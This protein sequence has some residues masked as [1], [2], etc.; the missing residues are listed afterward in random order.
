[1]F[2]F[3]TDID[4]NCS[5]GELAELC[6]KYNATISIIQA[7]GPAGGNPFI[8]FLFTTQSDMDNFEYEFYH[9]PSY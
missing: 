4:Y 3:R 5:I 6:E 9:G 8:S 2:E 7:D 1:M